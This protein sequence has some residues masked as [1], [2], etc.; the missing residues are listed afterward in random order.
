MSAA[1]EGPDWQAS[2]YHRVSS[3]QT[4]WG[5]RVLGALRLCGDE[6]V[7][8]AGCGTGRLTA[9]ILERLPRGRAVALDASSAMLDMARRELAPFGDRVSF[10]Q[11]VLAADP[12]PGRLDVV[13]STAT[14]HW[15]H[16]HE[17]LFKSLH[18]AIVP[19][20]KLHAECG[21][22]GNLK[23]AVSSIEEVT[24]QA[25]Y[26]PY[27]VNPPNPWFFAGV[28]DTRCRL[29]TAGFSDV[30]VSLEDAP[31]PFADAAAYAEF[32]QTVILR[33]FL[34]RLP[35]AM[36]G[37]FVA[38][39]TARAARSEPALTLDYVRLNIRATRR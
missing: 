30:D 13:F 26:R 23:R 5:E 15:V 20:G 37:A 38:D 2:T 1:T 24:R 11:A 16:D 34:P 4:A 3:P 22:A 10:V 12:I 17:A 36:H 9:L 25:R 21:G 31:T 6:T 27:F 35:D 8:D 7:L 32:V 18:D 29:E 28:E 39:V 19:G 14:F 33:P